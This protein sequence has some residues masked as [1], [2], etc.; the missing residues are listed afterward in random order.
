MW[1]SSWRRTHR[2]FSPSSPAG[3]YTLGRITPNT[4]AVGIRSL[5]HHQPSR[6]EPF[7]TA[8]DSRARVLSQENRV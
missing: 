7:R 5:S 1:L 6:M 4:K 3:T 2:R 8:V